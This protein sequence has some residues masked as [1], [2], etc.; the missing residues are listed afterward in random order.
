MGPAEI[1]ALAEIVSL[2]QGVVEV[3]PEMKHSDLMRFLEVLRI[4]APDGPTDPSGVVPVPA[5]S[6]V[7]PSGRN[8]QRA[9]LRSTL[10]APK[11]PRFTI[12]TSS[13]E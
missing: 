13:D 4:L 11:K 8:R 3:L 12:V 6:S 2:L 9:K 7:V 5:E 10:D 1:S